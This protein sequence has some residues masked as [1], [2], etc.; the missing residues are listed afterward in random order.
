MPLRRWVTQRLLGS[1]I[2]ARD[3]LAST[4]RPLQKPAY[5]GPTMLAGLLIVAAAVRVNVVTQLN[6][7]WDEFSY[8]G[9]VH[10]YLRRSLGLTLQSFHVHFFSWLPGSF[11]NEADQIVAARAVMLALHLFTATL[12]YRIARRWA[13]GT[14]PLFAV[15]AYLSFS[16][17]I[18][19]GASFR[20]DTIAIPA[21]MAAFD[22]LLAPRTSAWRQA[23]AGLLIALA[24]VITIKMA[25]FLPTLAVL[26]GSPLLAGGVTREKVR[27]IV[28]TS[29]AAAA[30]FVLLY[31]LH[32]M[33]TSSL[34]DQS[35]AAIAAASL[36]TAIANTSF[37][38]QRETL[39]ATLVWDMAFWA[40]WLF[41]CGILVQQIRGTRGSE[42]AKWID[43]AALAL[44][45]AGLAVYRNS[46][47]YFYPTILAPAS[48]LLALAW[49]RLTERMAVDSNRAVRRVVVI[50][51]SW[52]VASSLV[53]GL[54]VPI[55]MPLEQQRTVIATVHQ[56]F[57]QSVPYLDRC[58]ALASFPQAGFFMTTW[59]LHTYM[60][61]RRPL[62][63]E[64]INEE[65]PPL[66]IANHPLLNPEHVVYPASSKDSLTLLPE[67]RKALASAYIHHWGPIYVAGKHLRPSS[68]RGTEPVQFDL[69]IPGRY[70]LEASEPIEI[71][72]RLVGPHH[73]IDLGRGS[74]R[75]VLP[76]GE[77][78]T[79]RWGEQ[80]YRPARSPPREEFFLGF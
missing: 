7:N 26:L 69:L 51:V 68:S 10:Q 79:L 5:P 35:S 16:F 38:P 3:E 67:D 44:P 6:I 4:Q 34:S 52:F 9:L 20:S 54:Y 32:G 60:Q 43:A 59:N 66:L 21:V 72:G 15:A 12:L 40:L 8:L 57:P 49:Q 36:P 17:V 23:L 56:M 47:P 14:S 13:S 61:E 11:V 46:F 73:S 27:R 42:R 24:G 45:V 63:L 39:L 48:I 78:A 22:L 58:S 76:T 53:H 55:T 80:L 62:L 28:V 18:R 37:L 19:N 25:I 75:A 71:D 50:T 65:G 1:P 77:Q 30:G 41:G 74:H 64:A 70:T 2:V 33:S 31:G 29:M